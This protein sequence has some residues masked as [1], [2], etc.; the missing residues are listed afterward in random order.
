MILTKYKFLLSELIK[1]EFKLKYKRSLLGVLWSLL[2]PLL[3]MLVQY[4]VFSTLFRFDIPHYPVYL[5]SGTIM[6]AFF[7]EATSQS[8]VSITGNAHL[9][10]KVYVSKEVF[11][12]SKVV[13]ALINFGFSFIALYIMLLFSGLKITPL[14]LLLP[15]PIICMVL[16]TIGFGY[17][18]SAL[19]VFFRDMQFLHGI[20][21]TAWTYFTPIFYPESILP[22]KVEILMQ[23]NPLYHFIRY[24]RN[25]MIDYQIPTFRAH[26]LC[27][28]FALGTFFIGVYIFRKLEN[29]FII[30]L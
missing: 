12:I 27:L 10:T 2:N 24:V 15:F 13:S 25:I 7:S 19:M 3:I 20:L 23:L 28:M 9:I 11:P 1:R 14:H 18:L 4:L 16:F 30:N 21:L 8:L 22:D 6:F 29:K 17:I 5:L 26:M